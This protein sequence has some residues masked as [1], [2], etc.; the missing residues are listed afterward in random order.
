MEWRRRD[1]S[2]L[3]KGQV[4]DSMNTVVDLGRSIKHVGG[5]CR[6]AV[7]TSFSVALLNCLGNVVNNRCLYL[8]SDD[9]N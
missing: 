2:G 5:T 9:N 4:T 3:A 7:A 1:S 8:A 6:A